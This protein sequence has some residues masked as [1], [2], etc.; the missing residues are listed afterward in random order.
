[1]TPMARVKDTST[2]AV[3]LAVVIAGAVAASCVAAL[4]ASPRPAE[5]SFPGKTL[6]AL[7]TQPRRRVIFRTLR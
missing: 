7:F 3:L 4:V 6:S 2:R 1:M 5:A